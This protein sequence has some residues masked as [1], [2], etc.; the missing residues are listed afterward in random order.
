MFAREMSDEFRP[1]SAYRVS[2]L[3]WSILYRVIRRSNR[4]AP[5]KPHGVPNK[6]LKNFT[7]VCT[8]ILDFELQRLLEKSEADE[9]YVINIHYHENHI[10]AVCYQAG[11][12]TLGLFISR[13]PS[14]VKNYMS[15][16]YI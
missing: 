4:S 14:S 15:L 12:K 16:I 8:L 6:F 2:F 7:H 5:G 1:R 3:I 9:Y 10:N 11:I 13:Y